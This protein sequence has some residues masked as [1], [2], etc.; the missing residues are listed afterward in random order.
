M[1]QESLSALFDGECSDAEVDRLLA[2][3][4]ANPEVAQRWSR[5]HLR[6][7]LEDGTRVR[8]DQPCICAGVMAAIEDPINQPVRKGAVVDLSAWRRRLV[9]MPWKPA[10]GFAAAASM[11]AAAVLFL[12][13]QQHAGAPLEGVTESGGNMVRVGNSFG[14]SGVRSMGRLRSVSLTGDNP[15]PTF[16]DEEYAELLRDYIASRQA[17]AAAEAGFAGGVRNA[18]LDWHN[19]AAEADAKR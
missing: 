8:K 17:A 13:P 12:A 2:S 7:E 1:P 14:Q 6:R 3:L 11:G 15:G 9:A 5:W 19:V 16:A 10:V 18:R 4:D